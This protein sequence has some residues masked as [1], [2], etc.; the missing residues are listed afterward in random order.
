VIFLDVLHVPL[1][2]Q[3]LLSVL[4]LTQKHSFCVVIESGSMQFLL[5]NSL[6]FSASI[7]ANRVALLSGSTSVASSDTA[8]AYL[9]SQPLSYGLLHRRL[10]HLSLGRIQSL[11]RHSMLSGIDFP[12]LPSSP[13]VC[14]ACLEGKQTRDPFHTSTSC[15][16]LPLELI[17]SDLHGPV[18]VATVNSFKYWITFIDDAS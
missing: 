7:G 10:G 2:N 9:A 12:A 14:I 16:S 11:Q 18:S 6:R 1:I 5:R 8:L 17:H 4:T 13:D 15:C 3:N